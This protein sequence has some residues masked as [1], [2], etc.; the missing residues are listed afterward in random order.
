MTEN[1]ESISFIIKKDILENILLKASATKQWNFD[2]IN[3]HLNDGEKIKQILSE[4]SDVF[5]EE[6]IKILSDILNK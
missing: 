2:I 5:L 4:N 3:F 6:I 1:N